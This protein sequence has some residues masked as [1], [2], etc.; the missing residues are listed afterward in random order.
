M[1]FGHHLR[2]LR[3]EADFFVDRGAERVDD[4][5][6]APL[7]SAVAETGFTTREVCHA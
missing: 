5:R 1:S 2:A 3:G 4:K 6:A 7:T